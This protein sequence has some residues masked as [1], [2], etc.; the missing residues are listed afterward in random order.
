MG[1]GVGLPQQR[2]ADGAR[3]GQPG[4]L[5]RRVADA[6]SH[7]HRE[8]R[9]TVEVVDGAV[10]GVD[11]PRQTRGALAR[12]ALLTEDRVVGTLGV[13]ALA[14]QLLA[15]LVHDG[16]DVDLARLRRFDPEGTRAFRHD[17][18]RGVVSH[19]RREIAQT[20][21]LLGV[22]PLGQ[23]ERC[24]GVAFHRVLLREGAL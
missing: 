6:D 2:C 23:G 4:A 24:V 15:A 3:N 7:G 21:E 5:T 17:E 18:A 1:R 10:D 22:Q 16:D 13:D 20:S 9:V 11:D 14:Q 19:G 8:E 12:A